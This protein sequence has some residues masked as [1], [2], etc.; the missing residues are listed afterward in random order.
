MLYLG[1]S[2]VGSHRTRFPAR[3]EAG[4]FSLPQHP[5]PILPLQRSLQRGGIGWEN[6]M[7]S[8]LDSVNRTK[9]SS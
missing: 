5:G 8:Y 4:R 6:R 9:V 2:G 1:V 7:A 3:T